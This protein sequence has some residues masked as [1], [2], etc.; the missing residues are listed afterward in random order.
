MVRG[1]D[2]TIDGQTLEFRYDNGSTITDIQTKSVWNF[3]GE[4]IEGPMRGRTWLVFFSM[5]DFGSNG[6][7]FIQ[8]R[9]SMNSNSR[10]D[11]K[12]D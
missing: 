2:K 6:W 1:Y 4:S 3:N 10:G 8:T 5:K 7:H 12:K 11:L 9:S